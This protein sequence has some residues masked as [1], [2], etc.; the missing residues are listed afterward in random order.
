MM[1]NK[2]NISGLAA[3]IALTC[4]TAVLAE[5]NMFTTPLAE[6]NIY[7]G[8]GYGTVIAEDF[9]SALAS[10]GFTTTTDDSDTVYKIFVGY[11]INKSIAIEGGYIDF[12]DVAGDITASTP[13]LPGGS[14]TEIT[15]FDIDGSA[16][17]WAVSVVGFINFTSGF[18]GFGKLGIYR[19]NY[20]STIITPT[21]GAA[22]ETTLESATGTDTYYGIGVQYDFTKSFGVRAEWERYSSAADN[23]SGDSDRDAISASFVYKF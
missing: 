17:A 8:I 21:I 22:T 23:T 11:Q 4:S 20:N 12:G 19:W 16:D 13:G 18:S 5:E 7:A 15:I 9:L 2:Y 10:E 1:G 3:V 14:T 6:N